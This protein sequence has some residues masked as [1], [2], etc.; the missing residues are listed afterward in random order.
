MNNSIHRLARTNE[1]DALELAI[2]NGSNIDEKDE[3][4][5]TALHY[6]ISESN[7]DVTRLLLD[8]G[9]DVKAQDNQGSTP[10]H[11]AVEY[12]VIDIVELI[13]AKD[14]STVAISDKHGNQPLWTA[15]FNARGTY[16]IV[17]LLLRNGA[18]PTHKNNVE[19]SPLELAKQMN[20]V[21]LTVMLETA[22]I[23]R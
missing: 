22:R 6:S 2:K 19:K 18:D 20:E 15:V 21:A 14:S 13:L 17:Q 3:F 16:K 4:D 23:N 10:L 8:L 11:Y 12:G 5:T 7:P 9:A 1:S